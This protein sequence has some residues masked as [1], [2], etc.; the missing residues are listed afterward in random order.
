[1]DIRQ[2]LRFQADKQSDLT[3]AI[4]RMPTQDA[5]VGFGVI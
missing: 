5:A 2:M 4:I 3:V 1:M